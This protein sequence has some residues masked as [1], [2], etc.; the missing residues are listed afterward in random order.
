MFCSEECEARAYKSYHKYECPLGEVTSNL[1][2]TVRMALRT[3][4]VALAIFG[5]SLEELQKYLL[6]HSKS[7][8]VFE[9]EDPD[10]VKQTFLAINSLIASEET[11]IKKE[12]FEKIFQITPELKEMWSI[13]GDFIAKFLERQTQIGTL[14]YHEIYV[15]PLGRLRDHDLDQFADSL[16]Y[17][18]GTIAAGNG[19]YPFFSLINHHCA[20]NIS[21]MFINDK[22]VLVVQRPVKEGDQLF[23]N[24]GYN[25]TNVTKDYRQSELLK[26]YR[27][28]C[29]C[30]PCIND[31]PILSALK[32][33]DKMCLNKAK[34]VCRELSLTNFNRKKVIA[35]YRELCEIIDKN[36]NNFP[37]IE[38][39]SMMQSAVAYLEMIL[40]P[41]LQFL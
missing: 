22:I 33:C 8:T 41:Q 27:F 19:S 11:N 28:K 39:C 32:I 7:C 20:P 16:A 21:R 26:Q 14:N 34:K 40:K 3:F 5:E 15:W 38:M 10:E 6:E 17:K 30:E 29:N 13:H 23:D 37:S 36:Q 9:L 1:G 2:A 18:R 4:F 31:W 12:F 35:K 25:F 24:Y